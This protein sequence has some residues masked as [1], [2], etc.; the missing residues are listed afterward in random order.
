[1]RIHRSLLLFILLSSAVIATPPLP[2]P[3]VDV[4]F[5]EFRQFMPEKFEFWRKFVQTRVPRPAD[6]WRASMWD[7]LD[8]WSHVKA[9]CI[10]AIRRAFDE[11]KSPDDLAVEFE[12]L[13]LALDDFQWCLSDILIEG[14]AKKQIVL[15]DRLREELSDFFR[16]LRMYRTRFGWTFRNEVREAQKPNQSSQPTTGLAPGRG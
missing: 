6:E 3:R 16:A 2:P 9:D 14:L 5:D 11:K 13:I 7:G 15:D 12:H 4:A 8:A 1:M 10:P